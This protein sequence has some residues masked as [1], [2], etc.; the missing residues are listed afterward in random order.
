MENEGGVAHTLGSSGLLR[1][2]AYRV[3]VFQSGLKTSGGTAQM[4]HVALL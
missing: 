4:V 2:E 1:L 3:R